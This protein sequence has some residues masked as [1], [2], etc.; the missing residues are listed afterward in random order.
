MRRLAKW[1]LIGLCLLAAL[2]AAYRTGRHRA[3]LMSALEQEINYPLEFGL[4]HG[5]P[6]V[7]KCSE[8][9]I[10][11]PF[12]H[13]NLPYP[14]HGRVLDV[15]CRESEII[16]QLAS[17][18][19]EAWGIDIRPQLVSFPGIHYVEDD[20]CR[21]PFPAGYFDV[22]IALS[23][24]EHIGLHGYANTN[25]DAD[26]DLH[27]LQAVR[28][29]LD[30]NGRLILTVPFGRRGQT[31]WYRVYDHQAL[32]DLLTHAGFKTETE[33]YWRQQ[34]IGWTPGTWVVAEQTDSLSEDTAHALAC[35]LARPAAQP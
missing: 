1:A 4:V 20:V 16:F 32:Q 22:A 8:R 34:G 9:I 14:F 5:R 27:A 29:T 35:V 18:G 7:V 33:D 21:H 17:L 11:V 12:V 31:L 28:R 13:R 6:A 30:P 23:T 10:E 3:R 15:G 24:V 19:Y 26:G 25:Y 2:A